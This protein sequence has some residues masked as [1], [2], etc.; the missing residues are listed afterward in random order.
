LSKKGER[1]RRI[2]GRKGE[3]KEGKGEFEGGRRI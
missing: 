3:Y 2:R 1:E